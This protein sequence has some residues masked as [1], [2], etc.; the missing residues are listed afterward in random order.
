MKAR[1]CPVCGAYADKIHITG[2]IVIGGMLVAFSSSTK[3]EIKV[4]GGTLPALFNEVDPELYKEEDILW[5]RCPYCCITVPL[6][7]FGQAINVCPVTGMIGS[8]HIQSIG[9]IY[10]EDLFVHKS[11]DE[12]DFL[13]MYVQ[14]YNL[15]YVIER[16]IQI[17]R[18]ALANRNN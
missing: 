3:E 13:P 16:F 10:V 7:E 15:Q 8:K 5:A 18:E 17:I 6:E 1:V 9:D 12:E 11:V 2:P 14:E 4:E